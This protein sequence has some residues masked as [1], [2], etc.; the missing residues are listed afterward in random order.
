[1]SPSNKSLSSIVHQLGKLYLNNTKVILPLP[2]NLLFVAN[3]ID[4]F[5]MSSDVINGRGHEPHMIKKIIDFSQL[6][7]TYV[8]VGAN[9]GDFALQV[10]SK[11]GS[12][13]QIYAFEPGRT[14]FQCF[15]M[16]IKLNDIPNIVLENS[17]V[18]DKEQEI[19]FLE[20]KKISLASGIATEENDHT[21]KSISITLDSY[22]KDK[23]ASIDVLRLDAEG[24]ECKVLRG[25]EG[26]IKSSP[27]IRLFIE[28]QLEFLSKHESKDS[29]K[30]CLSSLTDKGF[31]F[32]DILEVKDGC[33]YL[34]YQISEDIILG[35][36]MVEFL[37][38]RQDTLQSFQ[39]I[40]LSLEQKNE[41]VYV[42][43]HLTNRLLIS[44]VEDNNIDQV[45]EILAR[46]EVNVNFYD[47]GKTAL[48]V[49]TLNNYFKLTE[50]LLNAGANPNILASNAASP[51]YE[52]I[53]HNNST[54]TQLL[55]KHKANTETPL[56]S[57]STPLFCAAHFGYSEIVSLLLEYGA[58]KNVKLHSGLSAFQ[59]SLN[60]GHY[61]TA[62][63]LAGTTEEFCQKIIGTIY[64]EK[65]TELCNEPYLDGQLEL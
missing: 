64:L 11:I 7:N 52:T 54:L 6:G 20:N 2:H 10:T 36:Y 30:K 4:N 60:N 28:W 26:I 3:T 56:D 17:A 51:L 24:S 53:Q 31:I 58:N 16:S 47:L 62:K 21:Q 59:S 19:I 57:G 63:L 43:Y 25:A 1:M 33:N 37:A 34:N 46:K 27:N 44:S 35:S 55:L 32:L 18:S 38:I 50:L 9:Y 23:E 65:F 49:S 45:R 5:L 15:D 48:Y 39:T 13:G 12:N 61:D 41:C 22:F 29:M 14:L 40:D 8:E 42:P